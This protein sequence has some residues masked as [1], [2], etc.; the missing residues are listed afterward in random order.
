MSNTVLIVDDEAPIREALR[1]AL[2]RQPYQVLEAGCASEAFSLL[3]TQP[4]DLVLSDYNMP[5]MTGLELLRQL[6]L[7]APHTIR[8]LLTGQIEM[9][10]VLEAIDQEVI[11]HFLHKPWHQSD[12]LLLIRHGLRHREVLREN[13]RLQALVKKQ[14]QIIHELEGR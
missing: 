5:D 6:S 1:R 4:V 8:V 13:E 3:E 7:R 9:R 10:Q 12:L 2:Q 11:F 14:R